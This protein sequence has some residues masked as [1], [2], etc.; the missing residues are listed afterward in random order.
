MESY[1]LLVSRSYSV[2]FISC[3]FHKHRAPAEGQML[4]RMT[5]AIALVLELLTENFSVNGKHL[6]A[7]T[8]R[9]KMWSQLTRFL[10]EKLFSE[11]FSDLNARTG[12][13][14]AT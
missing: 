13:Q 2:S 6:G 3:A 9:L 8:F 7:C 5:N 4:C 1:Q 14:Q 11:K 10:T 12:L